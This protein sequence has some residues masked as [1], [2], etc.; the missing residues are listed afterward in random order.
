ML[1]AEFHSHLHITSYSLS[2]V[3]MT[4]KFRS[5]C[6]I[7]T[8][9]DFVGDRWT[10]IILRDMLTGKSRYSEFLSSPE[11]ITTNILA[12][13]LERMVDAGLITREPY[14]QR[15][16]RHAYALTEMGR[17]LHPMLREICRWANRFVPGTWTPPPS[18]IEEHP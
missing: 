8:T 5:Q 12:D 11:R 9:L 10:L 1:L 17:A 16:V 3:L 6:P 4:Q 18:F 14:Q 2:G 13:R 7:A 15:P